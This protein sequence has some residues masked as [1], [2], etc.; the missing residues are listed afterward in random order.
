MKF[1]TKKGD[2][3]YN[4]YINMAEIIL[5]ILNKNTKFRLILSKYI[6]IKY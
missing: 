6:P 2:K 4:Y 1:D 5:N 3:I